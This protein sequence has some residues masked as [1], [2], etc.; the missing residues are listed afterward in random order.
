MKKKGLVINDQL[1]D[2][3]SLADDK[4][5]REIITKLYDYSAKDADVE[6]DTNLGNYI[7]KMYRPFIDYCN[8]RWEA[9][10]AKYDKR[11]NK[12]KNEE[13]TEKEEQN[14]VGFVPEWS[15]E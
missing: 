2:A 1:V 4:E 11:H 14:F 15:K 12:A 5:F 7:F 3:L 9:R 10:K 8:M 6:F 13:Y